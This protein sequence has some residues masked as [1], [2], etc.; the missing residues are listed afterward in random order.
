MVKNLPANAGD[1]ADPGSIPGSGRSPGGGNGNPRQ[2]SC[3]ENPMDRGA[4]RATIHEV[5]KVRLDWASTAAAQTPGYAHIL[6]TPHPGSHWPPG[7]NSQHHLPFPSRLH[8]GSHWPQGWTSQHHPPFPS[9]LHPLC[10]GLRAASR[11]Q[12]SWELRFCPAQ[13]CD[14]MCRVHRHPSP[15]SSGSAFA[16]SCPGDLTELKLS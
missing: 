8:P 15:G 13:V 6:E 5:V 4:W 12:S 14:S 2:Y 16:S 9:R 7:W 3:L 10:P 11:K 1:A